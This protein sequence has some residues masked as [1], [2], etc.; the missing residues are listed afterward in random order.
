MDLRHYGYDQYFKYELEK[1]NDQLQP[2]R[3]IAEHKSGYM[4]VTAAGEMPACLSGKY[5]YRLCENGGRPT[6]GDFV[7]V[8]VSADI[9][10]I[11]RLL[12]RK[13]VFCRSDAWHAAGA[14]LLAAN[15]DTV[16]ICM[17]LNG[18]FNTARLERYII[19]AR[20]SGAQ[21]AVLLTKADLCSDTPAK[22]ALCTDLCKDTPVY[23]VSTQNEQGLEQVLPYFTPC[24]TVVA[25]GSSGVGKSTLLNAL[26]GEQIMQTNSIRL[27][28][29]R[30]R[31]TTV[32][33]QLVLLPS[34][35]LYMDT[36]GLREI[37]LVAAEDTLADMYDNIEQTAGRCR[38]SDCRHESEPGCAILKA[39]ENGELLENELAKYKKYKKEAQR[40]N[41]KHKQSALKGKSKKTDKYKTNEL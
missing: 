8:T 13:T 23:A 32:H 9:A 28:D 35:G 3:I 22:V 20:Q 1:L 38:F 15:F 24:K 27:C 2:A 36:P 11:E 17:A 6:V 39:I 26:F 25:L 31:H 16:F 37:G 4:A 12:P 18:D 30:G 40:D 41:L 19:M 5:R 14:Q 34:G 7:G 33:R 29:S 10:V 21:A